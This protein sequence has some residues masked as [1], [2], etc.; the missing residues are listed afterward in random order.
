MKSLWKIILDKAKEVE[1]HYT[2]LGFGIFGL[3][4]L[5]A[6]ASIINGFFGMVV[7]IATL[8]K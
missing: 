5:W 1:S 3:F 4:T 7:E 6:A 2:L 8:F